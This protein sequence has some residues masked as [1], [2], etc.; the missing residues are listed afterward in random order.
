MLTV[1]SKPALVAGLVLC[2]LMTGA[3]AN[4]GDRTALRAEA[5][6]EAVPAHVPALPAGSPWLR[7]SLRYLTG[8]I[9]HHGPAPVRQIS[10]VATMG[11]RM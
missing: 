11:I 10:Q 7:N 3:R 9:L 6:P 5:F 1:T 8:V 2:C 4:V